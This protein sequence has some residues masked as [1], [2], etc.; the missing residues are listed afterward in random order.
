[1]IELQNTNIIKGNNIN[2]I[3][4]V[5][6]QGIIENNIIGNFYINNYTY[7][8]VISNNIN[9]IKSEL[10]NDNIIENNTINEIEDLSIFADIKNNK[11]DSI[12][13]VEI[14]SP[15]EGNNINTISESSILDNASLS[16]N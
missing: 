16:Y 11:I 14:Y 7:G 3:E 12:Y 10:I 8:K 9:T 2:V 4:K 13:K 5:S 1:V 6:N 15:M